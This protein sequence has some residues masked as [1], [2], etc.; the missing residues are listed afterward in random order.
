M[1]SRGTSRCAWA[2]RIDQ[3]IDWVPALAVCGTV[4]LLSER[5]GIP[6]GFRGVLVKR[7]GDDRFAEVA[8][9]G[10]PEDGDV[11]G[12][13][14]SPLVQGLERGVSGGQGREVG[15]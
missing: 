12:G 1:G 3:D 9:D 4:S 14:R 2:G 15:S 11:A 5:P 7:R 13:G 10:D 8:T 6:C